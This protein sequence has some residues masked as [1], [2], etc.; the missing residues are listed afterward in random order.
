MAR[1]MQKLRLT[2]RC[3]KIIWKLTQGSSHEARGSKTGGEDSVSLGYNIVPSYIFFFCIE[4][5]EKKQIKNWFISSLTRGSCWCH[6]IR[7]RQR[8]LPRLG[9]G[10]LTPTREI[11]PSLRINYRKFNYCSQGTFLNF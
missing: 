5:Y 6:R 3:L 2:E 9:L 1:L 10:L 8:P 7:W 4:S 11:A